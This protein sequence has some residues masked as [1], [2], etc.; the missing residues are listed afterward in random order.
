MTPA[1]SHLSRGPIAWMVHNRV[2]PNLLMLFLL[3]GGL[4]MSLRIR[5]EVF[6]EFETDLV[7]VR[8]AYPGASPEEVEQGIILAI[9]EAVRGLEGVK[10]VRA[11]ASEGMGT[12]EVELLG[13]ANTQKAYMDIK[14][15]IDRII[16]FPRDAEEPEVELVMRRREVV[17]LAVHGD[18][19][20][21]TLR[22]VAEEIRD[23]LLQDPRI[24]Q[25]DFLGARN[26]EVHVE[27][28]G[29]HLRAY[30]LTLGE[31]AARIAATSVEVPGGGLKTPAGEVLVRFKERR[32]WAREFA[33]IPI[34]TSAS[35]S[36]VRLGDIAQVREGF[37]DVDIEATFNGQPAVSLA[38]YRVGRQTPIS[39]SNAVREILEEIRPRLPPGIQCS[40]R[41]D[42]SEVYRQR[43]EL[44]V[45]NGFYGL[46]LVL[47]LLGL[48]LE[49]KLA[50][51]VMMGIP[52]S[53]LGSLILLPGMGVTI[54]MISMFAYITALGIVVD[55]AI[56][57]GENI[58]ALRQRGVDFVTAAI[59]GAREMAVPVAFSILTNIV[60]FL[61]LYF[62]PGEFGKIWRVIPLVVV[63][64]FVISW[65][66]SLLVLPSHLAHT[67]SRPRTGLTA[68][69][70]HWQQAFGL[71][72]TR[73]VE[74]RFGPFLAACLRRRLLTVAVACAVWMVVAAWVVSGRMGLILMPRIESDFAYAAATLPYG[75]P[76]SRVAEVRDRLLQAARAVAE[77][78]GGDRLVTG[79]LSVINQNTAE[80]RVF[81]T[82]PKQRPI[83]TTE[84]T[85]L[86]RER[87]G[88][89]VGVQALQ[90]YSDRG[91]PGGGAALTIELSHRNIEVLD[92]ASERLAAQLEEFPHV[93]DVDD[94][95]TPGKPQFDFVLRPEGRQLGLTPQEVARQIRH[96]FYGA[97]ALRQQRGRNEVKVLVRL[98]EEERRREFTLENLLIRTP[99]GRDVPLRDIV[100]ASRGRAY[101]AILRRDG[102]RTVRVTADVDPISE[103]SKVKET[104]DR[105]LLPQLA[106][107]FPGLSYG[108]AG[109]Q[110]D[111]SE[112]LESLYGGFA[113]ALMA[114]YFLLA[115]PFRSYGHPLIVMASIPFGLVGA[116]L[117]H[118]IMG[119][120]LSV[121]SMMGMVALSGVVVN[122]A[123]VLIEYANHRRRELGESPM[124]A[125]HQA[126]LRRFRPVLLTTLTTF[127]GLAPMIFE[128]S[129]QA[130]FM[131]PMALSLGYGI[132]FAALISLILV[133]C[134]YVLYEDVLNAVRRW[135]RGGPRVQP[136]PVGAGTAVETEAASFRG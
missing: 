67:A 134:L 21:W 69:L 133:P 91:G 72:F 43:L 27:V 24:T 64:A 88:P 25:V 124:E 39:V 59:R 7:M 70:H 46:C 74:R 93:R 78:H 17:V 131:I 113:L 90:F 132:L 66:E 41:S 71:A 40:I 51:W 82:D 112:S 5:K 83:S 117:G 14:Q 85:R 11:R 104:L 22:N 80:I 20:E 122:G 75:S 127:G 37:Q 110:Q 95:Y 10:E 32:D 60:A 29:D 123:L 108:Y 76:V 8:V 58:Y 81:L 36:V 18:A 65:V 99:S 125:I 136:Q 49:F 107:D 54:N 1:D 114:I 16:T 61:P 77:E 34:I 19:S 100:E 4:V 121:M 62:M 96:A 57:V 98:P 52:V 31:I 119:Y 38:V 86:W 3:V 129:R 13:D 47:L 118:L 111:M 126:A 42:S 92:R 106:R 33:D 97:E 79:F 109:R 84:F 48:F 130:R 73:W 23:R 63:T 94:G 2:T 128:T 9:E 50:F 116:V 44:L 30:G 89:V 102:R 120:S 28:P 55:D 135:F 15:A 56:I 6:P 87:V 53:F 68:R 26:Y 35:G 105:T 12:V 115:V 103:T 45:K 101:T